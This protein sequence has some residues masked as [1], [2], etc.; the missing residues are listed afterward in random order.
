MY[1]ALFVKSGAKI[2]LALENCKLL[3]V[4]FILTA[5]F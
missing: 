5:N 2:V 1:C 3:A 4:F